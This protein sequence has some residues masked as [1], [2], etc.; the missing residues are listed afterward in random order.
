MTFS[1]AAE[2]RKA[3]DEASL[4]HEAARG[5]SGDDWNRY[6][7]I[8]GEH[9]KAKRQELRTYETEYPLRFAAARKRLIDKAG[10]KDRNFVHRWFGRDGFDAGTINRRA[11]LLVQADQARRIGQLEQERDSALEGLMRRAEK[12]RELGEGLRQD[13]HRATDRRSDP[14]RR[15]QIR[16]GPSR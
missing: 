4:R 10:A 13:F 6:R 16:S 3:F 11:H 2:I 15:A 5:L 9:A 12:N 1:Y 7:E 8:L 14:D